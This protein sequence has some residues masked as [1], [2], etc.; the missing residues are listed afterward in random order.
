M[1]SSV[2]REYRSS[3][4][5]K[6][7]EIPQQDFI[8]LDKLAYDCLPG[9]FISMEFSPVAPL[10]SFST[11]SNL[12][13]NLAISTV[14]HSE[15]VS[16][17]TPLM[18]LEAAVRRKEVLEKEPKSP[19]KV[20]LSTSH[21]ILRGQAFE[22]DKFTAHFR[23]FALVTAGRDEG[24][25]GFEIASLEEHIRYYLDLCGRLGILN[26]AEVSLSDFTG[27]IDPRLLEGILE[28]LRDTQGDVKYAIDKRRTQA[29]T[30]YKP[31]AFRIRFRDDKGRQWDLVDGGFTDWTQVFLNNRKERLLTSAIG[32]EL[33]MK[34]FPGVIVRL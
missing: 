31:L 12:S 34:V 15:V 30:Y 8:R 10:G 13:Q 24:R 11:I 32:S 25:Y 27:K 22:N 7:S 33:L 6:P 16:D 5:L 3:R 2:L 23:V 1:P 9:D 21:R 4:F 17:P 20:K 26:G 28:R 18:A 29:R 19:R 14:R